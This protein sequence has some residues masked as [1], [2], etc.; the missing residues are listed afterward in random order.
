MIYIYTDGSCNNKTKDKGG[1]G[2]VIKKDNNVKKLWNGSFKNSTS[3]RMEIMAVLSALNYLGSQPDSATIFCDNQYVVNAFNKNWL[4][5][6]EMEQFQGRK[7]A[8]MWQKI[9][10]F[11]DRL[12]CPIT[13]K[14]V[15]GHNNNYYNELADHL[16]KKGSELDKIIYDKRF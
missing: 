3:S 4:W 5:K 6:W 7:N 2:V 15:K 11:Y 16:A 12:K 8:D 9:L 1:Y 14:W 13:F 10:Y